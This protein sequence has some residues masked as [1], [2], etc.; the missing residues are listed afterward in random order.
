MHILLDLDGTLVDT[1]ADRYNDIKC[2]RDRS[3]SLG[4][5]PIIAGA[6]EFVEDVKNRGHS[7][8]IVSDSHGAYV[9]PVSEKIFG[10]PCLALADKPNT[11]KLGAYLES[12]FGFPSRTVAEEFLFVGDTRLDIQLAR[13]LELPS[14]FLFRGTDGD[15]Y[16]SYHSKPYDPYHSE[17][18]NCALRCMEGAT[19]NCLSFGKLLSIIEEPAKSRLVLEDRIGTAAARIFIGQNI[20]GGFTLIRGL[21]RQQQ[22]PCDAYGAIGRYNEFGNEDR[23]EAFLAGVAHDVRRYLHD[24]VMANDVIRW[25]MI[26]CVADK[27]TTKPP[28]KNAKLL[29]ALDLDL[30]TEELFVWS[31]DVTGSTSQMKKRADRI[32]FIKRFVRLESEAD[33]KGKNVI[34]IDDQ[35]TTGATAM[36]HVEMLIEE[37]VQNILFV[38]L[39]YLAND[40]PV[41]KICP[42]CGKR[43]RIKYRK[44]DGGPFYS[45]VPPKYNGTG[46]GWMGDISNGTS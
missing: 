38:A 20:N 41:K 1:N 19:Y 18:T 17:S 25:D 29:Q 33:L 26:T 30:P 39:F 2:G 23:T 22:G 45:C 27:A 32:G 16:D 15:P 24:E 31:A 9:G 43:V 37:G 44:R 42:Q 4:D 12:I 36:L 5:I 14:A 11:A 6:R 8:T 21:G 3:F 28:R 13:G 7:V 40:V 35:Y 10:T 34:V 46:C